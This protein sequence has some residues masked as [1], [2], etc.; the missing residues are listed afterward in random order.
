MGTQRRRRRMTGSA[1][2]VSSHLVEAVLHA[3]QQVTSLDNFATGQRPIS[4]KCGALVGLGSAT[5]PLVEG[6][7]A[8]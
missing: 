3:G 4:T 8:D 1:R 2:F 6:D 5:A 7:I